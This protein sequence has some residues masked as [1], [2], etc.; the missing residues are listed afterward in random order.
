MYQAG[1]YREALPFAQEAVRV[2]EEQWGKESFN[3]ATNLNNLALIRSQLGD[4]EG[5]LA[6]HKQAL[7]IREKI[8][9]KDDPDYNQSLNNIAL[10][11]LQLG[12]FEQAVDFALAASLLSRNNPKINHVDKAVSVISLGAALTGL[13]RYDQ[14]LG[15]YKRAKE[16]M[17]EKHDT[18]HY[19][20][21][22]A[23]NNLADLHETNG[24]YNEALT[25]F[26]QATRIRRK[27]VGELH[28]LYINSL[29]N[30]GML[31]RSMNQ[32]QKAFDTLSK[33]HTIRKQIQDVNDPKYVSGVRNLANLSEEVGKIDYAASLLRETQT[34][35]QQQL[36]NFISF[37]SQQQ[38][39]DYLSTIEGNFLD[40]YA[41]T[42]RHHRQRPDLAGWAFNA[43]LLHKGLLLQAGQG[44]YRALEQNPDPAI[45]KLYSELKSTKAAFAAQSSA[46]ADQQTSIVSLA[47]RSEEL[48]QQLAKQSKL[49][50]DVS[51]SLLIQWPDIQRT[52]QPREA[53]IEF[54]S[55]RYFNEK[56]TDS[57]IYAA[58]VVRP[59]DRQPKFVQLFEER[60][61]T[62]LLA[63]DSS[64]KMAL[65]KQINEQYRGPIGTAAKT[66]QDQ[67]TK[68]Q[69]LSK[70]IWQPLDS[71][72]K[73]VDTVYYA[74]AGLLHQVAFAAL[75]HLHE[76]NSRISDRLFLRQMGSTRLLTQVG[77]HSTRLPRNFTAELYG[78]IQYEINAP[79]LNQRPKVKQAS[80]PTISPQ[81]MQGETFAELQGT[82]LELDRIAQLLRWPGVRFYRG[83]AATEEQI[84][85][86]TERPVDV[87]HIAT[88]GFATS[89]T[90]DPVSRQAFIRDPIGENPLLRSG[91]AMA[92]A[93]YIRRNGKSIEGVEDG[94]LTGF[95]VAELDLSHTSL[96][97]LSA[98]ET[99][100]GKIENSEGVFGLQRAFKLA[101]ARYLLVSLWKVDDNATAEYMTAFYNRLIRLRDV[102]KAYEQ[103]Q[104]AFRQ[105]SRNDPFKWSAFVL[106]E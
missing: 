45:Q 69:A 82:K 80:K 44:F 51:K 61:L 21:A 28:P 81:R 83:K 96:V 1:K 71:L 77:K 10:L 58:F 91:L 20:Y 47:A 18:V 9:P 102:R 25:L 64:Q 33:A 6:D 93:N 65:S 17:E 38:Q 89:T 49:F 29:N 48:I 46:P 24:N 52:L 8:L 54:I 68:G 59:N 53:A 13:K 22:N 30:L 43:A 5:A 74:P 84:K 16:I 106:V 41:F 72:L 75:P 103:T 11:Y 66:T 34:I 62:Q 19:V 79:E 26:T 76:A 86:R 70:L 95:E 42:L 12:N 36:L 100:L 67:L 50:R 23:L 90:E 15:M 63:P 27:L 101:G 98:C 32:K 35:Y 78:A 3:Y 39:A 92:G 105:Q 55:F 31:Y 4:I 88:H 104:A 99:G 94:I 56:W 37:T 57:T 85:T 97:C 40:D 60:Q 87:L 2:S 7:A 73:D 14:A